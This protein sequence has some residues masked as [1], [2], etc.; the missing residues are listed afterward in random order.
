MA[1]RSRKGDENAH[2]VDLD[3][4]FGQ[5][6]DAGLDPSVFDVD[7]D[8]EFAK[9]IIDFALSPEFMNTKLWAKQA[10][11]AVR[12]FCEYCPNCS[13]MDFLDDVP[14]GAAMGTFR[15]KVVLLEHGI[16]PEC[17]KNKCEPAGAMHGEPRTQAHSLHR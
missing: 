14:V 6:I 13:D 17:E 10:E 15:S 9:N 7:L 2:L 8:V 3:H 16:C 12:L 5:V 4:L 1:R 11:Q